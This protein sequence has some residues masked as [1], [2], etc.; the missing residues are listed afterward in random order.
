METRDWMQAYLRTVGEQIR[1]RAARPVVLRELEH[2]LQDQYEAVLEA[3]YTQDEARAEALRQ[4]GDPVAVGRDLDAVHRPKSNRG[5]LAGILALLVLNMT[6]W[7]TVFQDGDLERWFWMPLLSTCV[8]LGLMH[9]CRWI[10]WNRILGRIGVLALGGWG[11]LFV[12]ASMF[13]HGGSLVTDYL[14]ALFPLVYGAL[15]YSLRKSGNWSLPICGG[16]L[17]WMVHFCEVYCR[18]ILCAASL[19]VTALALTLLMALLRPSGDRKKQ[20]LLTLGTFVVVLLACLRPLKDLFSQQGRMNGMTYAEALM[21]HSRML[22]PG[23]PFVIEEWGGLAVA[24][25]ERPFALQPECDG[26]LST[27][28]YELGWL[29]GAVL[30]LAVLALLVWCLCR[31]WKQPSLWGKLLSW[32]IV[33]PMAVRALVHVCS[34]CFFHLAN[35]SLPL[36]SYGNTARIIDLALLGLLLS[37]FRSR[38]ILRDPVRE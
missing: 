5:I 23:A 29:P 36:L 7:L 14:A 17:V 31:G 19:L 37:L 18:G 16:L 6:I 38:S 3:G 9:L 13:Y 30:S 32:A 34:N 21:V 8:G 4:M 22:G 25:G 10:P 24:P 26:F 1:W 2:H 35:V 33:L 28:I 11:A 12:L 27:L 20:V 15:L